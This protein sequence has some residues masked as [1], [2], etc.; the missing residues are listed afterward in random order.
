MLKT[1]NIDRLV[2]SGIKSKN[3]YVS[4]PMYVTSR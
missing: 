1:P 3:H 4:A 2:S